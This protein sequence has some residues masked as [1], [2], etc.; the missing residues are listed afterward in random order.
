[1][2]LDYRI[3]PGPAKR[4][5]R[6][7]ARGPGAGR[8]RPLGPRHPGDGIRPVLPGAA[9]GDRALG[10]PGCRDPDRVRAR[11]DHRRTP[12]RWL[13]PLVLST[14]RRPHHATGPC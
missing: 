14:A 9:R 7:R 12:H 11:L 1:V 10:H 5:A 13:V 2:R 3:G 8:G 6:C 4:V